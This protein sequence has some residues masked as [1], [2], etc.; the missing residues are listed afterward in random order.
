MRIVIVSALFPPEPVISA[1]TSA[2]IAEALVRRGHRVTVLTPYP[3]RPA[4]KLYPGF[5]RRLFSRQTGP[6]GFEIRRCF[7]T[8]SPK[9]S[10]VSRFMENLSFGLTGG[11]AV[12][13]M[14]RPD[15]LYANTWPAL[16][17]GILSF[18]CRI[19]HIPLVISIQ[20]VYPES[21]IAQGRIRANGAI[22]RCMRWIDGVIAQDAD[23]VIVISERF[24]KIY[25]ESRHVV[26]ERLHVIPNW[27][28]EDTI[29]L[30]LDDAAEQFRAQKGIP[31][32]ALLFAYGGNVGAASGLESVIEVFRN[33]SGLE[34]IYLL[35]GGEGS[36]LA[37]CQR[38]ALDCGGRV[39]FHT[40]WPIE[41]TSLLLRA[42]DVLV[43]PTRGTQSLAS[44]PSK[45]ITYMLAGRPVIALALPD[46]D[47]AVMIQR[48]GC[49]WIVEPD[50][51][52]Q[53]LTLIQEI[54]DTI[55]EQ[56][57]QRG[58]AGRDFAL[59][60]LT[61]NTNVPNVVGIL[62]RAAGPS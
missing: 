2:H 46:S 55:P 44:M 30:D 6:E 26:R 42:A 38:L 52:E 7:S 19:R 40:P 27:L 17:T 32:E 23:V 36:H 3:S 53:L 25:E 34:G 49:G 8:F 22:A 51:P 4:G 45:L 31:R 10:M 33:L 16:A 11:W 59:R 50:R 35:I 43:L 41:E 9:S 61:R 5:S 39:V 1:Q 56:R 57:A 13:T 37:K 60:N 58:Q 24:A 54:A 47:M 15:V 29:I 12:V 62:E 28:A 20:D 18:L 48:S 14:A 21:L